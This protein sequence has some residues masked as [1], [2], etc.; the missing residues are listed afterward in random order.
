[1]SRQERVGWEAQER[2]ASLMG[3]MNMVAAQLVDV[4]VEVLDADAWGEG[5]GLRSPEHWVTWRTGVSSTRAKGLVQIVRR[6]EELPVRCWASA[7][8]SPP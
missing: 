5:G 1:M 3:R 8:W 7:P 2:A 4:I 6:L